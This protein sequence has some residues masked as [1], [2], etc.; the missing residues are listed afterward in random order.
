[1]ILFAI[2]QKMRKDIGWEPVPDYFTSMKITH[3]IMTGL[4]L[5]SNNTVHGILEDQQN[6]LWISTNQGLV[7]FNPKTNTGQTYDREN[8][9]EVTEF[10]DGAFYKDSRTETLFF[11]GQTDLLPSSLMLILWQTICLK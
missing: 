3:I 10:S 11:G 4:T 8:G 6:N 5:F 9:L 1:M 7:R 2:Y